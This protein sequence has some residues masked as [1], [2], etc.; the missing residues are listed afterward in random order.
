MNIRNAAPLLLRKTKPHFILFFKDL[1]A[2]PAGDLRVSKAIPSGNRNRR[3]HCHQ[4]LQELELSLTSDLCSMY[5]NAELHIAAMCLSS[6]YLRRPE[7]HTCGRL[8]Q[9][10]IISDS[11]LIIMYSFLLFSFSLFFFFN[12]TTAPLSQTIHHDNR[13]RKAMTKNI[14][15]VRG[16]KSSPSYTGHPLSLHHE[17]TNALFRTHGNNI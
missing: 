7:K 17:E 10:W 8:Y 5:Q 11:C 4:Y 12:S 2:L 1:I 3:E 14:R 9:E 16:S 15:S 13:Q 6:A